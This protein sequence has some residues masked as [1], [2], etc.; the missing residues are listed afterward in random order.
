MDKKKLEGGGGRLKLNEK[1]INLDNMNFWLSFYITD[2][3]SSV[4]I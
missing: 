1:E 3:L 2:S 4:L